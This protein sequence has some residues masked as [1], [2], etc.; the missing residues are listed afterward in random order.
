MQEYTQQDTVHLTRPSLIPAVTSGGGGL[1]LRGTLV[2][3]VVITLLGTTTFFGIAHALLPEYDPVDEPAATPL[4][5]Q[6]GETL[7]VSTPEPL[8]VTEEATDDTEPEAVEHLKVRHDRDRGVRE[9]PP[10]L[11][12]TRHQQ[13]QD[14][15]QKR[16]VVEITDDPLGGLERSGLNELEG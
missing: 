3:V 13:R 8:E 11:K 16:G 12:S 6:N 2:F 4:E 10:R 1:T 5:P 14:E 7:A 15:P 9:A